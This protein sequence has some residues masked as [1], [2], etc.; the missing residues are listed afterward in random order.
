MHTDRRRGLPITAANADT[1]AAFDSTIDAYLAFARDTGDQRTAARPGQ[2][3][4]ATRLA[5]FAA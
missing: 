4:Y 5:A 2:R 3:F 1:V